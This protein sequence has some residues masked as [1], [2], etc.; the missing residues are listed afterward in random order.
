MRKCFFHKCCWICRYIHIYY[1]SKIIEMAICIFNIGI[2]L[3][4][5]YLPFLSSTSQ[6]FIVKSHALLPFPEFPS[7]KCQSLPS[8]PWDTLSFWKTSSKTTSLHCW[9]DLRVMESLRWLRT[10][11]ASW[12]LTCIL[13][14]P[15]ICILMWVILCC[16]MGV[17]V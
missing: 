1:N 12:I 15:C 16:L 3:L 7:T 17:R 11:L 8:T 13:T 10:S 14:Y 6:L 5:T 2:K 4:E 9:W